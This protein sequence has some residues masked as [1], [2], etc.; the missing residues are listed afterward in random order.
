M[1]ERVTVVVGEDVDDVI[2]TEA[3]L[4]LMPGV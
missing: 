4:K 1:P 2:V 3:G